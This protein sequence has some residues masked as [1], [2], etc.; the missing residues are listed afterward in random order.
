MNGNDKF[1]S[2]DIC[3]CTC[4]NL[5]N[6]IIKFGDEIIITWTTSLSSL[7]RYKKLDGSW[8]SEFSN[9]ENF[10]KSNFKNITLQ[11]KLDE[12]LK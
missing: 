1:L 7:I 12:I 4:H 10:M 8:K 5:Y 9:S 2:G 11:K 3:I 6:N